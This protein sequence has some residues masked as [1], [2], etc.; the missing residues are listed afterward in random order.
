[1]CLLL[2]TVFIGYRLSNVDDIFSGCI[3]GCFSQERDVQ[4]TQAIII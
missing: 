2:V 1:M 3:L 4:L